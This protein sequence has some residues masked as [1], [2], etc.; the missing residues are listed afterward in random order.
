MCGDPDGH[1]GTPMG[2]PTGYQQLPAHLQGKQQQLLEGCVQQLEGCVQLL[3]GCVQQ[4]EG[5]VQQL[6]GYIFV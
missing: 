2:G 3:E 4:L 5:C 1:R 6:E